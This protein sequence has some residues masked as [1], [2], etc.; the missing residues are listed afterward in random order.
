M[1][2][3]WTLPCPALVSACCPSPLSWDLSFC[4]GV[5]GRACGSQ[6]SSKLKIHL[7]VLSLLAK[8]T[9]P[10]LWFL[11]KH[12]KVNLIT[13]KN[14]HHKPYGVLFFQCWNLRSGACLTKGSFVTL[15]LC[16]HLTVI[17]KHAKTSIP[18]A[19]LPANFSLTFLFAIPLLYSLRIVVFL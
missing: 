14:T 4:L 3:S 10:T 6:L 15:P 9:G 5:C 7:Q 12:A 11:L 17:S 13:V 1:K 8:I 2:L 18:P 16:C 19:C